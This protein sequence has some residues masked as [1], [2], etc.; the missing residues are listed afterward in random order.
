MIIYIEFINSLTDFNRV[1]LLY[2]AIFL[3]LIDRIH[4]FLIYIIRII[5]ALYAKIDTIII[6]VNVFKDI[7]THFDIRINLNI[8]I[9]VV[10]NR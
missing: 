10:F 7:F 5:I 3:D 6:F 8:D 9:S 4:F 2:I 1:D